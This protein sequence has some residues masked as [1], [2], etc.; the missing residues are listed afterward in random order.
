MAYDVT[1]KF[2]IGF[3]TLNEEI[4]LE[5]L[6]V[7]G[8]IPNWLSGTLIRNG[9]AKFEVGKEKFRHWFD[10]L[11][12]LHKF[13][14]KGG[15]VS[16]ANKFLES[17]AFKSA[18]K[19]D[20]ISYREFA[21]D[22][23][24][25]IFKRVSSMFSTKF[26]DNANVNITK[27]AERFVAMTET[28]LP[29]EFDINTLKTVGVFSYD[30]KI[31]SGLTTALLHDLAESITGD[32]MPDEISKENKRLAENEAMKEILAKL[33]ENI[34]I[35]YQNIWNEYTLANTK[36]S[37]LLHDVDKLEMAIQAVKYSSEG[38]S[39]EKLGMFID[40]AKKRD[41]VKRTTR[42]T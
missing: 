4:S 21:T 19:T 7:K 11:A 2:Q 35:K 38:F 15:K 22:P 8:I 12:M 40:S 26:T 18:K 9:P 29:V 6:P 36:E 27:I 42:H 37:V 24:R 10:G 34:A 30:D 39:N 41:Q 1:N 3:S 23:C 5:D 31:E 25:S 14:F 32:F 33:P 13:S 20:R 16:Y 28:P 17:E